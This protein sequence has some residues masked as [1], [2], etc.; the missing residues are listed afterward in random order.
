MAI[1]VPDQYGKAM[2]FAE[3]TRAYVVF[4]DF[5]RIKWLK[6][7]R[8]GYRHC[9]VVLSAGGMGLIYDPMANCTVLTGLM[10]MDWDAIGGRY[11][12]MGYSVVETRIQ[13]PGPAVSYIRPFTCVEAV[14]RVLGIHAPW[15][16]TP[17]QLYQ[18]FVRP[19]GPREE[20]NLDLNLLKGI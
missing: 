4:T 5:S 10:Q 6:W 13:S 15:V 12:E 19:C 16:L 20:K 1:L 9:F 3:G 11:R 18:Y 7:L 2:C 14:K 8:R 17:W